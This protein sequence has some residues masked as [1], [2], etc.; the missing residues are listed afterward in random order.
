[1]EE[2]YQ[3]T[4][5]MNPS[6]KRRHYIQKLGSALRKHLRLNDRA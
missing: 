1:L 5:K 6:Q 3:E 4:K 2:F